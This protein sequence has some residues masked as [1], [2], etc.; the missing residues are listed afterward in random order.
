MFQRC[1]SGPARH[2][3]EAGRSTAD[4]PAVDDPAVQVH[5]VAR[6]QRRRDHQPERPFPVAAFRTKEVRS[7]WCPFRDPAGEMM[8]VGHE[9]DFSHTIEQLTGWITDPEQKTIYADALRRSDLTAM[10]NYYRRNYPPPEYKQ[11]A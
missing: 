11:A 9:P 3:E 5:A 8:V 7:R 1:L 2:G 4:L 10:L 6:R